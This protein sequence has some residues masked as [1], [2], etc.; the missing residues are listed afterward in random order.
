MNVN[1]EVDNEL[2]TE[3]SGI[4]AALETIAAALAN[5][6]AANPAQAVK[7]ETGGEWLTL[8]EIMSILKVSAN[9]VQRMAREGTV[10]KKAFSE[11]SP[12]YRI[13]AA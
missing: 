5:R 9:T 12:R 7:A 4:R 1:L 11:R 10:E 13:K 8:R 2:L 3:L 6:D